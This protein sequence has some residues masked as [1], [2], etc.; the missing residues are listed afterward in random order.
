MSNASDFIIEN[1][2]LK[3]YVGPGGDVVI[4]DGVTAIGN[5]AFWAN[6]SLKSVKIPEGVTQIGKEAFWGSSLADAVLPTGLINIDISAFGWCKNLASVVI[7]ESVQNIGNSAFYECTN[8]TSV[9]LPASVP[10]I[11]EGAFCGCERLKDEN[12]FVIVAGILFGYFGDGGEVIV[13]DC[14]TKIG[15]GA[16]EQCR[17]IVGLVIPS[18]VKSVTNA[19]VQIPNTIHMIGPYAFGFHKTVESVTIPDSVMQIK[20][21]AFSGCKKLKSVAI[22]AGIEELE[23]NVFYGC[24][25]LTEIFCS[26]NLKRIGTSTFYGCEKLTQFPDMSGVESIGEEAFFGCQM[27]ADQKG[28]IIVN[29]ILFGYDNPGRIIEIPNEVSYISSGAFEDTKY[30]FVNTEEV[31]QVVAPEAVFAQVWGL[32]KPANKQA[33]A[34]NCLRNDTLYEVVN[35]YI[36]KS[37]DKFVPE[38][39][40]CDDGAMMERLFSLLKKPDLDTVEKYIEA[41]SGKVNVSAFLLDYKAKNF[42]EAKVEK[43]HEEKTEMDLGLQERKLKDWKEIFKLSVKDGCVRISGYKKN[44]P[45]IEIPE[46]MEGNPVTVIGDNAFKGNTTVEQVVLPAGIISIGSSAFKGCAKL[47][48]INIPDGVEEISMSAFEDCTELQSIDLPD[49]I[50]MI[51]ANAFK[52]CTNL[53]KV[54]LP[55]KLNKISLGLFDGCAAIKEIYLPDSIT[56]IYDYSFR[57]CKVLA[58]VNMPASLEVIG[59]GAFTNCRAITEIVLPDNV[60]TIETYAFRNCTKLT[61]IRIPANTKTVQS[62]AFNGCKKLTVYAPAGSKAVS[63]AKKEKIPLVAE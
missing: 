34:L 40:R 11:E 28:R 22:P 49:S 23:N 15:I 18:L 19:I 60:K 26:G 25:S 48:C 7:P 57:D 33:V 63:V 31:E 59:Q 56:A 20:A 4:P 39:I 29:G 24:N 1:G 14:V 9:M 41:A 12:G 43:R 52:G 50:Q 51:W 30:A 35:A 53:E 61:K 62:S 32:L 38:I 3:N 21:S 2:V 6:K 58:A 10:E 27:L 8:L 16:F 5:Q 55:R 47:K 13:P 45:V 36:K 42:T 17:G 37:K 46:I 54:R 44:E